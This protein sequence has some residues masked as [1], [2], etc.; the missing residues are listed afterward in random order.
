[1]NDYVYRHLHKAAERMEELAAK[2]PDASGVL[3]RTL[4][5]AARELLLAQSSDWAFIM[6]TGTMVEYAE[7]R[8]KDHLVNFMNLYGQINS[9]SID[10]GYLKDLESKNNI[11]PGINYRV[12]K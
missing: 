9:N 4:N 10:E 8:T 7:K 12:Y 11:F 1:A 6:T 5:Q 3:E 2:F